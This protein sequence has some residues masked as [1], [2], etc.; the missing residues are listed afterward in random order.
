MDP[1]K[2]FGGIMSCR[3]H[4]TPDG[5]SYGCKLI[6]FL[7]WSDVSIVMQ[8]S[9]VVLLTN[10]FG[11]PLH[12]THG[13]R[14]S[15]GDHLGKIWVPSRDRLVTPRRPSGDHQGNIWGPS[16]QHLRAIWLGSVIDELLHEL[17]MRCHTR[18]FCRMLDAGF[19]LQRFVNI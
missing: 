3:S 10:T 4:M 7:A 13:R 14:S 8:P 2:L 9:P 15:S 6:S 19:M 17:E 11:A 1:S 12:R 18:S 16:G 5:E